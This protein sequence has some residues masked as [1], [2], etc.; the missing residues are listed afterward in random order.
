MKIF[1]GGVSSRGWAIITAALP[2][3][4]LVLG[5]CEKEPQRWRKQCKHCA[6][7]VLQ[8]KFLSHKHVEALR[9]AGLTNIVFSNG[10]IN[11]MIEAIRNCTA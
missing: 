1:V 9:G 7:A 6:V 11:G 8:T 2:D 4:D 10:G 5:S 3:A